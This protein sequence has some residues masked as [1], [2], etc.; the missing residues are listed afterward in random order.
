LGAGGD[1]LP[2]QS[3][4]NHHCGTNYAG[5][6]SGW[7]D[8][9]GLAPPRSYSTPGRYPAVAEGV[10]EMTACFDDGSSH[11]DT[12]VAVGVVRCGGHLLWRLPYASVSECLSGYCTA[13]SGL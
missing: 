10:V 9:P 5:W 1:A 11:C 6:L 12:H 3:S 8:G 2:L 13:A 4:G 7:G